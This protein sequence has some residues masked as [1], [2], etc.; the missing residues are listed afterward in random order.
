MDPDRWDRLEQIVRKVVREELDRRK[1]KREAKQQIKLNGKGWQ[2]IDDELVASWKA[3]Y[4]LVDIREH[5][6]LAAAWCRSNVDKAP[7]SQYARF[8][9]CWLR[10]EQNSRAAKQIPKAGAGPM[11]CS[12]C[13]DDKAASYR[14]TRDGNLC[15]KCLGEQSEN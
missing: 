10:R 2:G 8:V 15:P 13:G 11:K 5:L 6:S 9:N 14:R 12:K 4:P 7:R 1:Q 3:A